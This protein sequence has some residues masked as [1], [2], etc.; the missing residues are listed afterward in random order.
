MCRRFHQVI[1]GSAILQYRIKLH[2]SGYVDNA[3]GSVSNSEKTRRLA[4]LQRGWHRLAFQGATTESF[5][6]ESRERRDYSGGTLA[7]LLFSGGST[8]LDAI[9]FASRLGDT[10]TTHSRVTSLDLQW[11]AIAFGVDPVSD[12]LVLVEHRQEPL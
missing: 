9:Q 5:T 1:S 10:F 4:A 12:L 3:N 6:F 11:P 8:R 7:T 2:E